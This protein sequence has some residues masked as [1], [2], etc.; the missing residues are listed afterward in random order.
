M[1]NANSTLRT[2]A[3]I[4]NLPPRLQRL[5]EN[6]ASELPDAVDRQKSLNACR[7]E[8]LSKADLTH[9]VGI[10]DAGRS[11]P[12]ALEDLSRLTECS[13]ED[14]LHMIRCRIAFAADALPLGPDSE[15]LTDDATEGL[16]Q[17]LREAEEA[18]HGL[19]LWQG[20]TWRA[21][22]LALGMRE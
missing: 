15:P 13:L 14:S 19:E 7:T 3:N 5:A 16:V 6:L 18:L 10:L 12:G 1:A 8:R 4:E 22:R 17:A 9:L 20:T 21:A 2:C 11:A